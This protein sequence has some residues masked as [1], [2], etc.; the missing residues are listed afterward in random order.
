MPGQAWLRGRAA[1]RMP[2]CCS[3]TRPLLTYERSGRVARGCFGHVFNDQLDRGLPARRVRGNH[4]SALAARL[5]RGP[6]EGASASD[7]VVELS[8]EG[9]SLRHMEPEHLISPLGGAR[10]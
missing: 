6:L 5:E 1:S 2:S 9:T 4:R 7:T 8:R 3:A 10:F